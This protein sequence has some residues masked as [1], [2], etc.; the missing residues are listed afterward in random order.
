MENGENREG[1]K[2]AAQE[3]IKNKEEARGVYL[4]LMEE[5]GE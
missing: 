4:Q 3:M 5:V 1:Q 2:A